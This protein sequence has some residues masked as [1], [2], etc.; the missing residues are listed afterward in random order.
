M[1]AWDRHLLK[2]VQRIM[3]EFTELSKWDLA[4]Y[5]KETVALEHLMALVRH[6]Q[7]IQLASDWGA[8]GRMGGAEDWRPRLLQ[9]R[10]SSTAPSETLRKQPHLRKAIQS[11][12]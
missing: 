6:R 1:F 12:G 8:L 3:I 10:A 2:I 5:A 7:F 11:T 9:A 4:S